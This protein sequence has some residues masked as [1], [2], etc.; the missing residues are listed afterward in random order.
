MSNH[1]ADNRHNVRVN[2]S[3][4]IRLSGEG[5]DFSSTILDLSLK[6]ILL[7]RPEKWPSPPNGTAFDVEISLESEISL[8]MS[9]Q[10]VRTSTQTVALEWTSIDI[11]S[12]SHLRR[13]MEFNSG[14][15]E[16]INQEIKSL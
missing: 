3:W 6:G 14:E 12:I 11:E 7:D 4:P 2:F 13:L 8:S 16:R 5:G 15:P 10:V 1:A 9:A